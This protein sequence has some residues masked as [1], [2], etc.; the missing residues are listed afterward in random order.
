MRISQLSYYAPP[1]SSCDDPFITDEEY[2]LCS[3]SV[4]F[5]YAVSW[6]IYCEDEIRSQDKLPYLMSQL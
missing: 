6:V 3:S 4:R 2:K 5:A 1:V